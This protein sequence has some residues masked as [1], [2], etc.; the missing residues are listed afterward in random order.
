MKRVVRVDVTVEALMQ[1]TY[2]SAAIL[3]HPR[4]KVQA[5][6]DVLQWRWAGGLVEQSSRCV[7]NSP[8]KAS[9][10]SPLCP[11]APWLLWLQPCVSVILDAQKRA[12]VEQLSLII[13]SMSSQSIWNNVYM[14]VELLV[15]NSWSQKKIHWQTSEWPLMKNATASWKLDVKQL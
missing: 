4:P 8:T 1:C 14:C 10:A 12:R 2:C 5:C 6:R 3:C 7:T 15:F 11:A 13:F 9:Q